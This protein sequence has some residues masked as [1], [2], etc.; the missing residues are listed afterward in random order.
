ML[1]GARKQILRCGTARASAEGGGGPPLHF[2]VHRISCP[3]AIFHPKD[4]RSSRA[5][6]CVEGDRYSRRE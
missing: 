1:T 4:M 5:V 3:I 6:G 2:H